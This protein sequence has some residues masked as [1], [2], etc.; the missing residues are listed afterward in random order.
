MGTDR[1]T[2]LRQ[3]F[4]LNDATSVDEMVVRWPRSGTSQKFQNVAANRIIQI[5]EGTD[6]L[7]EKK[8][9]RR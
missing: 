5:T 3:H 2:R 8:Y 1:R 4:G 7:V 6:E 9:V